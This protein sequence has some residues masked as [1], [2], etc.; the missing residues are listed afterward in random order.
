[1]TYT[2]SEFTL[3]LKSVHRLSRGCAQ[4]FVCSARLYINN[5]TSLVNDWLANVPVRCASSLSVLYLFVDDEL[6]ALSAARCCCASHASLS[7][8]TAS[9]APSRAERS[10]VP[11]RAAARAARACLDKWHGMIM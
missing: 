6:P 10:D 1:M 8:P 4:N 3:D 5:K 2:A 7:S 9:L 11:V